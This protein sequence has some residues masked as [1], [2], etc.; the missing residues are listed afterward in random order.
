[1]SHEIEIDDCSRKFDWVSTM[2]ADLDYV[3]VEFASPIPPNITEEGPLVF[4]KAL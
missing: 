3:K 1:M 4:T 2:G